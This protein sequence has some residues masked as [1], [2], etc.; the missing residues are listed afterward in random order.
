MPLFSTSN[1]ALA[2]LDGHTIPDQIACKKYIFS[3]LYQSEALVELNNLPI[4]GLI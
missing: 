2:K 1:L 3:L 4:G